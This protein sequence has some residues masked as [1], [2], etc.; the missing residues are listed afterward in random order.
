MIIFLTFLIPLAPVHVPSPVHHEASAAPVYQP[1]QVHPAPVYQPG[2]H[3]RMKIAENTTDIAIE[4]EFLTVFFFF[5]WNI[6]AP[7]SSA[8]VVHHH[9][10]SAKAQNLF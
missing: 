9:G 8:P 5:F 2:R 7:V 10:K 1:V 6:T 3:K 4:F